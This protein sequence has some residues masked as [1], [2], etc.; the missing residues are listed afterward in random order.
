MNLYQNNFV[1]IFIFATMFLAENCTNN[2]E[3]KQNEASEL[4]ALREQTRSNDLHIKTLET[5]MGN[6]NAVL[7]SADF[8][9]DTLRTGA[10]FSR[11]SALDRIKKIT[12]QLQKIGRAHV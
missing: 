9:L 3:G 12:S 10:T 7:D 5:A 2:K 1:I 11:D 8:L 6:I 4:E